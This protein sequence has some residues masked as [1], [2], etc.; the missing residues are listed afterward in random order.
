MC[1][2]IEFVEWYIIRLGR[3]YYADGGGWMRLYGKCVSQIS[4]A[5]SIGDQTISCRHHFHHCHPTSRANRWNQMFHVWMPLH[6]HEINARY[7]KRMGV[8]W[9]GVVWWATTPSPPLPSPYPHR[10]THRHSV[11]PHVSAHASR[12]PL[13]REWYLSRLPNQSRALLVRR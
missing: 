3:P 10:P 4:L 9:C 2:L 12:D 6:I 11:S 7:W 1:F 8:V 13:V 5:L